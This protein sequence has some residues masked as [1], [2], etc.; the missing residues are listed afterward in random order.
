MRRTA[1]G[2]LA[3]ATAFGACTTE[4]VAPHGYVA[5]AA[6][7]AAEAADH[8]KEGHAYALSRHAEVALRYAEIAQKDLKD[9]P[10]LEKGIQE[11]NKAILRGRADDV[12]E[13][14]KSAEKA[15]K[16]FK[17]ATQ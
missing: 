7:H 13:G 3:V 1:I 10:H 9:D 8:G 16:H 17:A 12:I 4:F 5:K 11:L 6:E 2:V 14:T 15:Y